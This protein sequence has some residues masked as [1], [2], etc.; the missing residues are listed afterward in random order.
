M[1]YDSISFLDPLDL[2]V[3]SGGI[4]YANAASTGKS[5][6]SKWNHDGSLEW[7]YTMN[8]DIIPHSM[9]ISSNE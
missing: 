2:V 4:F 8:D 7:S 1:K 3:S 9:S 5:T 6:L